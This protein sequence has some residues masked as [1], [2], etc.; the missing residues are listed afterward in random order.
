MISSILVNVNKEIAES[1][2]SRGF[3]R[4][5]GWN[6]RVNFAALLMNSD[7]TMRD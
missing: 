4:Y 7:A 5:S 6:K 2:F 1:P 3:A